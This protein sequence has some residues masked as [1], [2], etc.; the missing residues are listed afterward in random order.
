M[1][2]FDAYENRKR[3]D[4]MQDT[5]G[6]LA[7]KKGRVYKGYMIFAH[8]SYG[9]IVLLDANFEN[10]TDSPWLFEAMQDFI[11]ENSKDSGVYKWEGYYRKLNNGSCC[12]DGEIKRQAL[13]SGL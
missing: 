12:F 3:R 5:W 1:A 6:H 7:P 8:S 4:V 10:L 11:G 2:M 13:T 9:D